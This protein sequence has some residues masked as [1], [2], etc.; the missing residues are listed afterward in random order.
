LKPATRIN[1][2]DK[3]V[4]CNLTGWVRSQI[5]EIDGWEG[6]SVLVVL[7]GSSHKIIKVPCCFPS[8]IVAQ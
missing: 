5:Q 1:I 2:S 8:G 3:A 6:P 4:W 7:K